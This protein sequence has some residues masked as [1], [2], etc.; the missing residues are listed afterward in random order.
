MIRFFPWC[1]AILELAAGCVY[2]YHREWRFAILW[3][4]YGIAAV[5]LAGA[6]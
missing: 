3:F 1:V 5:A 2:L 6:K 4:G